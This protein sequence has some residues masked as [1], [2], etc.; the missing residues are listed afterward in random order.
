MII[1]ANIDDLLQPIGQSFHLMTGEKP[2][3][4]SNTSNINLYVLLNDMYII[5]IDTI[6]EFDG[7]IDETENQ[8]QHGSH[9]GATPNVTD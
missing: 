2:I 3:Y 6:P 1:G 8:N 9:T 4:R 7:S 5:I